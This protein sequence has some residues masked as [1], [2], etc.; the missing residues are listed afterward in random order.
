M[1]SKDNNMDETRKVKVY[2]IEVMIID[3]DNVGEE[4]IADVIEN[5][6]Y[7]NHCI[8][9]QVKSVESRTLEWND[10]HP[11]NKLETSDSTYKGLFN[12]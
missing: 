12:D 10:D 4:E 11:L 1:D 2:K 5:T 3:F 9:P 6:R 7:P 8:S